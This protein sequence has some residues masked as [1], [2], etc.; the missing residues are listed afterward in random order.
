[1]AKGS[2]KIRNLRNESRLLNGLNLDLSELDF[3]NFENSF[4]TSS[5]H[6]LTPLLSLPMTP[7]NLDTPT[8]PPNPSNHPS[9]IG[10]SLTSLL[11]L[12][13][14]TVSTPYPTTSLRLNHPLNRGT[15][16]L[17]SFKTIYLWSLLL[18]PSNTSD[19]D[20]VGPDMLRDAQLQVTTIL[21]DGVT[22]GTRSTLG[23][24]TSL[25]HLHL[26]NLN[27]R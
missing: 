8:L 19:T 6:Y 27:T 2:Q 10:L 21:A 20:W 5:S 16:D 17:T 3:D 18:P 1:M 13:V 26:S 14:S 15:L 7:F 11:S 23:C 22:F 9:D 4:I 25:R 12:D 24:F